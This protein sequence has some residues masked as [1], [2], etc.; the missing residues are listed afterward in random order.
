[1]RQRANEIHH[2]WEWWELHGHERRLKVPLFPPQNVIDLCKCWKHFIK[3]DNNDR[4][5]QWESDKPEEYATSRLAS[6]FS[7]SWEFSALSCFRVFDR[8]AKSPTSMASL[9]V[10][11]GISNSQL[12]YTSSHQ[13]HN[14]RRFILPEWRHHLYQRS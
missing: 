14:S 13:K 7:S 9:A 8:A 11:F 5:V 4:H 10:P 3:Y 6:I 12:I 1:V 2:R